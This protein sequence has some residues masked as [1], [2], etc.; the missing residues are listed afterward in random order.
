[1][2]TEEL[3]GAAQQQQQKKRG[4]ERRLQATF[5]QQQQEKSCSFTVKTDSTKT[6]RWERPGNNWTARPTNTRFLKSGGSNMIKL[7]LQ[8]HSWW[9]LKSPAEEVFSFIISTSNFD[10]IN[11]NHSQTRF[12]AELWN[13][14]S[15]PRLWSQQAE[16]T[17]SPSRRYTKFSSSERGQHQRS[18]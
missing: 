17:A 18:F 2:G 10:Q 16:L 12:K 3:S 14:S 7:K 4:S 1:M 15:E 5:E 13:Q 11:Q 8:L 9:F 6:R